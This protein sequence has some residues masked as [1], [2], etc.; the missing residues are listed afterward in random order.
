MATR[1]LSSGETFLRRGLTGKRCS[2][3]AVEADEMSRFAGRFDGL[4]MFWHRVAGWAFDGIGGLDD[5]LNALN[6]LSG[7][8]GCL[9]SRQMDGFKLF[10]VGTRGGGGN[11]ARSGLWRGD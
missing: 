11:G 2:G 7:H 5:A 4:G 9:M 6:A 10:G 1:F 8:L 3:D